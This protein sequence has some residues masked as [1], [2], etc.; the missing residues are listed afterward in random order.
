MKL[1]NAAAGPGREG[2]ARWL[3]AEPEGPN[4]WARSRPSAAHEMLPKGAAY[5]SS[6]APSV[7]IQQTI[8]EGRYTVQ[9]WGEIC[10]IK[11]AT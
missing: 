8:L 10:E 4:A 9:Q 2:R 1:D 5:R 11:P 7:M 6:G 3:P